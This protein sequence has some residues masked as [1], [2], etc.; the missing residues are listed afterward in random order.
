MVPLLVATLTV[1]REL[2]KYE[3]IFSIYIESPPYLCT[4]NETM[5]PLH[6][7]TLTVIQ[8]ELTIYE[9]IYV[10]QPRRK[11]WLHFMWPH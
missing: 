5:A 10:W 2:P 8:R 11:P 9:I 1:Q 3:T 6:M 4:K 7:A